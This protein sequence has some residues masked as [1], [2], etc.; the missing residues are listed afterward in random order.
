MPLEGRPVPPDIM[1]GLA[2][3]GQ[4]VVAMALELA[5]G[6]LGLLDEDD[7]DEFEL[8]VALNPLKLEAA[9]TLP[10]TQIEI[11]LQA[12]L[13]ATR[14]ISEMSLIIFGVYHRR[15]SAALYTN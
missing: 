2:A 4:P 14:Q 12:A 6:G 5:Y 15:Q 9:P 10:G 11:L 3:R 1:V 8:V 7:E 13:A